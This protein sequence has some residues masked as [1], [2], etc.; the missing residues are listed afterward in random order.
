MRYI[1]ALPLPKM[2]F[3]GCCPYN[4]GGGGDNGKRSVKHHKL[5]SMVTKK[6]TILS[7]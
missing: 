5:C 2:H 7:L 4:K 6:H 1:N 3:H